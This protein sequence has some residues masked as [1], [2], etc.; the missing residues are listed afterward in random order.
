MEVSLLVRSLLAK[1][2]VESDEHI[3]AFLE[4]DYER[5]THDP[6]LLEG[7]ER[8]V[9]RLLTAIASK[10]RIAVYAD[11]DCDGIP[12][13]VVLSDFFKKVGHENLEVYIPHRD[14]EGYGFHKEAIEELS[15]AGVSLIIIVDVGMS[16]AD[17]VA[18]A[19]T[20]LP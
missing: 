11:F 7:M 18:F 20:C 1:R 5:G 9:S 8:A 10:E 19:K 14:R 4:P 6:F 12:G 13:A 17:S 3:A 16:A 2:G 15:R